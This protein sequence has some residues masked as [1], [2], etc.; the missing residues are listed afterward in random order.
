VSRS[1]GV[2]DSKTT[3]LTSLPPRPSGPPLLFQEG[4]CFYFSFSFCFYFSFSLLLLLLRFYF[5]FS[6]SFSSNS[7]TP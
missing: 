4:S 5:Y 2:V 6:L 1:D 3:I 7:F